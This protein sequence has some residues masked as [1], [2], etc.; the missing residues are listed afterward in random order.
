V[1]VPSHTRV[2]SMFLVQTFI[3]VLFLV[4]LVL[5][6]KL[7]PPPQLPVLKTLIVMLPTLPLI[8]SPKPLPLPLATLTPLMPEVPHVPHHRLPVTVSL[9]PTL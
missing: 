6:V 5:S 9:V 8:L 7:V 2:N 4:P 1:L 3:T